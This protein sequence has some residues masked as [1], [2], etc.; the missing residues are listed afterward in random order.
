VHRFRLDDDDASSRVFVLRSPVGHDRIVCN[1][2]VLK[3]RRKLSV[4]VLQ[5]RILLQCQHWTF[6]TERCLVQI[7]LC[8]YKHPL[9]VW[10]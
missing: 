6:V 5:P 10:V 3:F 4:F 9:L 8:G 2:L 1:L 7:H